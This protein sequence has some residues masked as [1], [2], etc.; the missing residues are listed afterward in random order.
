MNKIKKIITAFSIFL[1]M[2]CTPVVVATEEVPALVTV[3]TDKISYS[4]NEVITVI[5]H[6]GL[7]EPIEHQ[8]ACSLTFCQFINGEW[9]CAVKDCNMPTESLASDS[10]VQFSAFVADAAGEKFKYQFEYFLPS[11]ETL[12]TINS[13]EFLLNP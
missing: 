5:V 2:S 13:N 12:Y 6:N 1:L 9:V 10:S 8:G 4:A 11:T 7:D 3:E